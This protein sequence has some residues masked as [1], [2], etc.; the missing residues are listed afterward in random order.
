MI[1]DKWENN[2]LF[3]ELLAE[4]DNLD[5][6]EVYDAIKNPLE[7]PLEVANDSNK[8]SEIEKS[9]TSDKIAK[10]EGNSAHDKIKHETADL[11]LSAM[12]V[13]NMS[14]N[15]ATNSLKTK[16]IHCETMYCFT[17]YFINCLQK[18]CTL[19]R[20]LSKFCKPSAKR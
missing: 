14:S 19:D 11:I 17:L 5:N 8:R 18:R 3:L 20:N 1:I 12:M 9:E 16:S 2:T 4:T 6:D 10:L 13:D 15:S 7:R